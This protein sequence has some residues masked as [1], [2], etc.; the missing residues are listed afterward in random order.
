MVVGRLICVNS[1]GKRKEKGRK[2]GGRT[3]ATLIHDQKEGE[4]RAVGKERRDK[5]ECSR[6]LTRSSRG[7]KEKGRGKK[8]LVINPRSPL[9][10]RGGGGA[11]GK[12]E[13]ISWPCIQIAEGERERRIL[14]IASRPRT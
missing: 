1:C 10:N 3:V 7:G 12:R 6:P 8:T 14:L 11:L 2:G 13:A 4:E 9:R 5:M